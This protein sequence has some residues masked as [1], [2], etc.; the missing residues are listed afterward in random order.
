MDRRC[1][2]CQINAPGKNGRGPPQL[3]NIQELKTNAIPKRKNVS[4]VFV[5][6]LCLVLYHNKQLKFGLS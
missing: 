6:M 5:F 4:D 1:N 3:K 2:F